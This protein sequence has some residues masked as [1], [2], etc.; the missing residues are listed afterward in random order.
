MPAA[1]HLDGQARQFQAAG[2]GCVDQMVVEHLKQRA[3]VQI[4]LGLQGIDQL[5]ERRVLMR[6]GLE[7]PAFDLGQQR[8]KSLLGRDISL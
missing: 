6:L 3:T 4:A 5:F 7:D 8:G 2:V 1:L